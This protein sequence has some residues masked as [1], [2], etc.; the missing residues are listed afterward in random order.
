MR[1]HAGNR[2]VWIAGGIALIA[3]VAA[4][5]KPHTVAAA[6]GILV[7]SS[8]EG[9]SSF[10]VSNGKLELTFLPQGASIASVVLTDDS[11]KMNPLW[12]P[13]RMNREQGREA[14]ASS[15]TGHMLC[16]DGFGPPS[17]DE[18]KAG[19]PFNGEATSQTFDI[20]SS[21]SGSTAEV[22]LI[23]KLPIVQEQVTRTLRMVD[24]ENVVYVESQLEN[25]M[26]FDRPINWGEHATIGSPFLEP[27]VTVVDLSAGRSQTTEYSNPSAGGGANASTQR[28]L[29]SDK[30]FRWPMAPGLDGNWVDMRQTPENPHYVDHTGTQMDPARKLE[31]TTALNPKRKLI[32]GYIFRR[33]DYP[34]LQTWGNY[35]SAASMA[36]GLEFATQPFSLSRRDATTQGSMFGTPTY[37]WLPAKSKITTKF[38]M[39]YAWVPE[40]FTKVDDVRLENGQIVVMDRTAEKEIRLTASRNLE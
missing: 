24:G 5:G 30:E 34:W 33:E 18:R 11:E 3:A 21:K 7:S 14:K 15:A 35:P 26:A 2:R 27:G 40:G 32:L 37:R 22:T 12:N 36:R 29:A 13:V 20:Q 10:T 16:V 23:A 28:R 6:D 39:F 17:A 8:F 38:L 1:M 9:S 4:T 25:L 19:F 31:W